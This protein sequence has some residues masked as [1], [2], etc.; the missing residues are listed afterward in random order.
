MDMAIEVQNIMQNRENQKS[1]FFILP[2]MKESV[3]SVSKLKPQFIH[4][5]I[6]YASWYCS[7]DGIVRA[8]NIIKSLIEVEYYDY[9]KYKYDQV[10]EINLSPIFF[11]QFEIGD[12]I[13]VEWSDEHYPAK[14]EQIEKKF[15]K[16]S[17]E[18]WGSEWDEWI[19]K[20]RI[21]GQFKAEIEWNG[22]WYPAEILQR[23]EKKYFVRYLDY[24]TCYDEWVNQ[25][26]IRNIK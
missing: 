10:S 23:K 2:N 4:K 3:I 9:N 7:P 20:N 21:I 12:L 26:R 24:D 13:L 8:T 15:Y 11:P 25:S 1:D 14:I 5:N 6:N 16:I 19:T 18:G 22:F 17:Y